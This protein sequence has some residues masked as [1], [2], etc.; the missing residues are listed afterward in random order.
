MP[1]PT[2]G[3]NENLLV[4][5]FDGSARVK[6][7]VGSYS[8]II[9]RLLEWTIVA[10]ASEFTPVLTVNEAEYLGF[11]LSFDCLP[12]RPGVIIFGDSNSVIR[13]MRVE[14]DCKAPGL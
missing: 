7:K 6:R 13:Q 11:L 12:V 2:L 5:S 9:W 14:I 4:D 1:P 8:A 10:A 3:V